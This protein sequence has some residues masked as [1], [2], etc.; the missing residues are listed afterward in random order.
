[1][2]NT[3]QLIATRGGWEYWQLGSDVFR[4]AVG[5]RG[6]ILPEGIPANARWECSIEHFTKEAEALLDNVEVL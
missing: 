6:Y 1:M 4:V 5:N 2:N 3:D